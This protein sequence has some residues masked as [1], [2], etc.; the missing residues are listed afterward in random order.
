MR[1]TRWSDTDGEHDLLG[2]HREVQVIC[3]KKIIET[4]TTDESIYQMQ[5]AQEWFTVLEN[6]MCA[7]CTIQNMDFGTT[8][9]EY[10][11]DNG[12]SLR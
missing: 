7:Q 4:L 8:L 1:E 6:A 5:Y 9:E 12:E 3:W 10:G 11:M 2:D